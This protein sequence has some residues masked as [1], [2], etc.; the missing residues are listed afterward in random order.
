MSRTSTR[1]AWIRGGG[2]LLGLAVNVALL[3]LIVSFEPP[4]LPTPE[5]APVIVP[6]DLSQIML[7]PRSAPLRLRQP[8]APVAPRKPQPRETRPAHQL[9]APPLPPPVAAASSTAAASTEAPTLPSAPDDGTRAKVSAALRG[10]TGCSMISSPDDETTRERC[11][12]AFTQ[13]DVT[14][15]AIDTVPD[16]KRVGYDRVAS[17]AED[18]RNAVTDIPMPKAGGAGGMARDRGRNINVH[19]GC[20]MK[21]GAGATPKMHCP[22]VM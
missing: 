7:P 6:V 3:A 5:A 18:R 2:F 22:G 19:Y 9:A 20:W 12:R 4:S 16:E 10:L 17:K 11:R 14:G 15:V 13:A 1:R 21:F 8:S